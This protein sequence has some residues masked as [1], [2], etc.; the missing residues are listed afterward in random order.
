M[1]HEQFA[2]WLHGVAAIKGGAA[3]DQREWDRVLTFLQA[4]TG[5]PL[6]AYPEVAEPESEI[7]AGEQPGWSAPQ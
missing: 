6:Y 2:F 1:T 3:P 4:T 7:A 5:V